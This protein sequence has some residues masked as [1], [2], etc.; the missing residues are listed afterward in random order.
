MAKESKPGRVGLIEFD[1]VAPTWNSH[2]VAFSVSSCDEAF[3]D[4]NL[5]V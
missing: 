3:L 2:T 5:V 1:V 4:M